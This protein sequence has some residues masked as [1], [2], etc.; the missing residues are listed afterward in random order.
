MSRTGKIAR[1]P[2]KTREQ[3]NRRLQDGENGRKIL[4]WLN[5]LPEVK[6]ILAAEFRNRPV[7]S[8][9]LTEWKQGG[10]RDWLV[11]LD[12]QDIVRNLDDDHSLGH[13][14]LTGP[15]AARLVQ[16]VC[17]YYASAA[18]ALVTGER[19][20]DV[21]WNRLREL[22]ADISRL[23]RSELFTQRLDLDR[24]WL[25]LEQTFT[26]ERKEKEF[27][28]WTERP[29]IRD[30]LRP[31]SGKGL[32]DEAIRQIE[33]ACCL[34]D[35]SG[36]GP[37]VARLMKRRRLAKEAEAQTAQ[38]T[39]SDPEQTLDTSTPPTPTDNEPPPDSPANPP[40]DFD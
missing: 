24:Q 38:P 32:T 15:F 35:P 34:M 10:Y 7:S 36:P 28:A 22:C 3:L 40:P 1:L 8:S 9:N 19:R 23:R 17:L 2:H 14:S 12:A 5:A 37:D 6:S 30:K 11:A 26:N 27:W 4:K 13:Q 29:D 18:R 39:A 33:E 20:P 16:W 31:P 25:A 21:R